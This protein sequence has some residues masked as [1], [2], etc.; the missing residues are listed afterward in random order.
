MTV[1]RVKGKV[2][3]S[4]DSCPASYEP[5]D[6][7]DFKAAWEEAKAE[8]WSAFSARG[9]FHHLCKTCSEECGG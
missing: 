3:F 5:G 8:G 1:Q 7:D 4:C 6:G 2:A 9:E